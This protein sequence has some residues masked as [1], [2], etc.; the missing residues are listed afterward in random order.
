M[1]FPYLSC[2]FAFY[3]KAQAQKTK[4]LQRQ[5]FPWQASGLAHWMGNEYFYRQI[6]YHKAYIFFL[7]NREGFPWS[8]G[9]WQELPTLQRMQTIGSSLL[10]ERW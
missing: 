7:Y 1:E 6:L 2:Y 5:V 9:Q 8:E 10:I 3:L 4:A